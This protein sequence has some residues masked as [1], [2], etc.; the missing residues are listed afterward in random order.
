MDV[1]THRNHMD[2]IPSTQRTHCKTLSASKTH[3]INQK[4]EVASALLS[5]ISILSYAKPKPCSQCA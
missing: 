2:T 3:H 1:R 4:V 5:S